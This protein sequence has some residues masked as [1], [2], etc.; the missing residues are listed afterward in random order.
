MNQ[1]TADSQSDRRVYPRIGVD[2]PATL[3]V[4]DT[5]AVNNGRV[6]ELSG[7]G[8]RLCL[9]QA[10][11]KGAQICVTMELAGERVLA[12]AEVIWSRAQDHDSSFDV[13][14][15]SID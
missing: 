14:C 12:T 7:S 10:Q 6:V 8:S 15:Q 2:Y 11:Q 3:R 9:T 5:A 4:H 13:A 1:N